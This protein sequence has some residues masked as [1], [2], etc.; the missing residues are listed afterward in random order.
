MPD[1]LPNDNNLDRS[2]WKQ[3]LV[4]WLRVDHLDHRATAAASET[5]TSNYNK[6]ISG[7]IYLLLRNVAIINPRSAANN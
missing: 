1:A 3:D 2:Q 4:A 6:F 5:Y 7:K